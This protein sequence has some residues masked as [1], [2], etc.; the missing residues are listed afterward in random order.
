M[1]S[2]K[3]LVIAHHSLGKPVVACVVMMTSNVIN[4][5]HYCTAGH[6]MLM[7]LS[8][9]PQDVIDALREDRPL[10]DAKLE[11]LRQFSAQLLEKRGRIGDDALKEFLSAGYSKAQ[12]LEVLSGLA[13]KLISN[14]ANAL[15]HTELDEPVK[16]YA[17]ASE[18]AA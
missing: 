3:P 18:K 16:P 7:K 8:K 15:A 14:F 9:M 10:A 13:S 11:A 6:T 17:W 5:C 2:P 1:I 4:Q 12:A